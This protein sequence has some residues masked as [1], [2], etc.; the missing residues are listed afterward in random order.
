MCN[1]KLNVTFQIRRMTT[2]L[3][4]TVAFAQQKSR[5]KLQDISRENIKTKMK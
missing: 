5:T 3:N 2:I 4:I 1:D